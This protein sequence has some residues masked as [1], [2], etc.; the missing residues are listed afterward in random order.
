MVR[1]LLLGASPG[2]PRRDLLDV[3]RQPHRLV[4]LLHLLAL[5]RVSPRLLLGRRP[6]RVHAVPRRHVRRDRAS[7]RLHAMPGACLLAR[8]EQQRERL[9]VRRR[10]QRGARRVMRQR[11]RVRRRRLPVRHQRAMQRHAG[12]LHMH[13]RPGLRRGRRHVRPLSRGGGMRRR[14][15]LLAL[16]PRLVRR[17]GPERV[18]RVPCQLD[19]AQRIGREQHLAMHVRCGV[20]GAACV[21]GRRVRGRRRVCECLGAAARLPRSSGVQQHQR[22]LHVRVRRWVLRQRAQLLGTVRRRAGRSPV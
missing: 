7:E 1:H 19:D 22:V 17:E 14:H 18:R 15:H 6:E 11:G 20:A 21:V 4:G 12:L 9:R 16:R 8:G 3:R 13:V 5:Q 10:L 2:R